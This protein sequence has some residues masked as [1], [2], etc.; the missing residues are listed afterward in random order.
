MLKILIRFR[1]VFL[2]CLVNVSIIAQ[3]HYPPGIQWQRVLANGGLAPLQAIKASNGGYALVC[4]GKVLRL[5]EQ[6]NTIWQI[7]FPAYPESIVYSNIAELITATPDGGFG[8]LVHNNSKWSVARIDASGNILWMKPF[9][10]RPEEGNSLVSQ[11]FT[12]LIYTTDGGF[13]A[14]NYTRN[15]RSGTSTILYKID[16]EGNLTAS[17]SVQNLAAG[18]TVTNRLIQTNDG[19]YILFGAAATATSNGNLIAWIA[20]CNADL[21][22]VWK[23]DLS[24]NSLEDV[25]PNPFFANSYIAVGTEDPSGTRTIRISADGDVSSD[26]SQIN[27]TPNTQS[28]ITGGTNNYTIVD[29]V[30]ENGGD[31]RL[32]NVGVQGA[33]WLKK[34]GG[35]SAEVIKSAIATDDGG[36]LILATTTS[37]DGDVQGNTSSNPVPWLVKLGP[38]C[39][40]ELYTVQAGNW[41]DP[42]IW[43]CGQIPSISDVVRIKHAIVLPQN[44]T[45]NARQIIYDLPAQLEY[46]SGAQLLLSQ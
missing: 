18:Y 16:T 32:L 33:N 23:K 21:V 22:P 24:G 12:T 11:I 1:L 8:V 17:Q 37:M 4:Q 38:P 27:R 3:T 35:S 31:V 28:L 43:S 9:A 26:F 41:N 40:G 5:S 25:I 34:L 42:A 10:D 20:K 29:I 15:G 13:L 6:G 46:L 36:Y 7:S 39:N 14:V 2:L 45:A 44:Y 30:N 19:N